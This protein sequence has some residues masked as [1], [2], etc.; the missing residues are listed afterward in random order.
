MGGCLYA[1]G[2]K[3]GVKKGAWVGIIGG[4]VIG[5]SSYVYFKMEGMD[6]P[7]GRDDWA[8]RYEKTTNEDGGGCKSKHFTADATGP[9]KTTLVLR[10][11]SWGLAEALTY[12]SNDSRM[13]DFRAAL[14]ETWG[15][16]EVV[17]HWYVDEWALEGHRAAERDVE[18]EQTLTVDLTRP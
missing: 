11:P 15:F 12:E 14:H 17:V 13:K 7:D 3:K 5:G 16:E 9:E 2:M 6:S 18:R 8:D 10:C 4:L 1:G